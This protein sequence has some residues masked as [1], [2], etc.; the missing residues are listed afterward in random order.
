[1]GAPFLARSATACPPLLHLARHVPIPATRVEQR[2]Q[3]PALIRQCPRLER[4][5]DR[6]TLLGGQVLGGLPFP[7]TIGGLLGGC[8]G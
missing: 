8:R 4:L 3:L 5:L 7:Q 6:R 1:M 2:V